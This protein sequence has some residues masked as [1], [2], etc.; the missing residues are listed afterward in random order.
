M[1]F[2]IITLTLLLVSFASFAE[3]TTT[4]TGSPNEIFRP[5]SKHIVQKIVDSGTT[6]I[7]SVDLDKLL[8][9][10]D[11][12]EWRTFDLGFLIGSSGERTTSIYYVEDRMVVVNWYALQNFTNSQVRLYGWALH[13]ALG[14]LGYPD[15]VYDL[16]I[17]LSYVAAAAPAPR[18]TEVA[19][20]AIQVE[21]NLSNV[22][23]STTNRTFST[24]GGSTIVGGGGDAALI[25]LKQRLIERF[26]AWLPLNRPNLNER[27]KRTAIQRLIRVQFEFDRRSDINSHQFR[28]RNNIVYLDKGANFKSEII[29]ADTYLDSIIVAL[30]PTLF[31]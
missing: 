27:Q 16:S 8:E 31:R 2:L 18:N 10:L 23:V 29:Y 11:T 14:A 12:V 20:R 25:D 15:D 21:R 9:D 22:S 30:V 1:R 4:V 5:L 7:G 24:E 13:E 17:A 26:V 3:G 28:I 6:Q 19:N